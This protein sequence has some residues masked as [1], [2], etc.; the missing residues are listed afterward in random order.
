[1]QPA[2][3]RDD[4][5]DDQQGNGR[6]ASGG[7]F[8]EPKDMLD[9]WSQSD[10]NKYQK[11]RDCHRVLEG[12]MHWFEDQFKPRHGSVSFPIVMKINLLY[13]DCHGTA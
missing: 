8:D 10:S 11:E 4:Q 7:S 12:G 3:R 9:H 2:N 6:T 1:M 13:P 5:S